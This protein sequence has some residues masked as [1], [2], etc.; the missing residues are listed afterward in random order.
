MFLLP[1][2][3][4]CKVKQ[5]LKDN[6]V[7]GDLTAHPTIKVLLFLHACLPQLDY[8]IPLLKIPHTITARYRGLKLK[9]S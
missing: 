3:I 4:L 2:D 9:L 8:K 5:C 6:V 7:Q 1:Y